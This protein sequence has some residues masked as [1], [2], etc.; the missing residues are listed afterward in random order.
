MSGSSPDAGAW[1]LRG[2]LAA[3]L[4]AFGVA[5]AMG[6]LMLVTG[7]DSHLGGMVIATS[8]I[9]AGYLGVGGAAATLIRRGQMP[10]LLVLAIVLAVVSVT[11]WTILLW[12]AHWMHWQLQQR[13]LQTGLSLT[14]PC[15]GLV[16]TAGLRSLKTRSPSL[17]VTRWGVIGL[18]WFFGAMV[19]L[20]AWLGE[21]IDRAMPN[22]VMG[23]LFSLTWI[24]GGL[25]LLGPLALR[26]M[27][28][29]QEKRFA[30]EARA[31]SGSIR[32]ALSCPRCELAMDV[33]AGLARCRACGFTMTI[34]FEEPRCE[35]GYLLYRLVGE[36][37][38]E[39]GRAVPASE[40]WGG[41]GRA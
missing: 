1:I 18:A 37:C 8:L 38:P 21:E 10:G 27:I 15:L 12:N 41:A 20:L 35:C 28:A 14:V 26:S 30:K 22:I 3:M 29:S 32:V 7:E 33:P 13:F 25:S 39:C 5:A 36:T 11:V 40:R 23:V 16:Y 6:I 9:A 17:H 31:M 24:L 2:I 34:E 4:A 19:L